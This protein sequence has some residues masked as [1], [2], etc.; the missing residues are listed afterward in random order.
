[1]STKSFLRK[2]GQCLAMILAAVGCNVRFA[3]PAAIAEDPTGDA[4]PQA[5]RF[6]LAI[7]LEGG[8]ARY[9]NGGA[10]NPRMEAFGGVVLDLA[11]RAAEMVRTI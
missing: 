2:R 8:Y 9:V 3:V 4:K 6:K 5:E 10:D 1:M 11:A 7:V